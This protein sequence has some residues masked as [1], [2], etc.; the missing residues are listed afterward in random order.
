MPLPRR[1]NDCVHLPGRLQRRGVAQNQ[2]GGPVRCNALF[3]GFTDKQTYRL[4]SA[5]KTTTPM[6]GVLVFPSLRPPFAL[7]ACCQVQREA[8]QPPLPQLLHASP[9]L[10]ACLA[11]V[12]PGLLLTL[13]RTIPP[14]LR[15]GMSSRQ[16]Q[17]NLPDRPRE[18]PK[19]R[20]LSR[21]TRRRPQGARREQTEQRQPVSYCTD[22]PRMLRVFTAVYEVSSQA[23]FRHL[24]VFL[25]QARTVHAHDRP[26][27][28]RVPACSSLAFFLPR[29][30]PVTFA[31]GE[32]RGRKNALL[33][34]R[35]L[36]RFC[37]ANALLS[38][39]SFTDR[40]IRPDYR[41]SV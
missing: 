30:S 33:R 24:I 9:R 3:G 7:P 2:N 37:V 35:A 11:L 16:L 27:C 1:P 25:A 15:A 10:W 18:R 14:L 12:S 29:R 6:T 39:A 22:Y 13:S 17:G 32:R 21:R 28:R 40:T 26:S 31:A 8:G 19:E 23:P 38:A 20:K 34:E 4:T 36:P 5:Q 41:L